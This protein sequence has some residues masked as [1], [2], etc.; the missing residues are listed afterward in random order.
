MSGFEST[1]QGVGTRKQH[2]HV[3][4]HIRGCGVQKTGIGFI[5]CKIG[6]D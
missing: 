3:G 2:V 5:M 1:K 4:V 6:D